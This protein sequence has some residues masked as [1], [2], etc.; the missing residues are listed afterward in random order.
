MS[1]KKYRLVV[2]FILFISLISIGVVLLSPDIYLVGDTE[3]TV[4]VNSEYKEKG[5]KATSFFKNVTNEVIIDDNVDTSKLGTYEITYILN[6]HGFKVKKKRIV[7]VVDKEAPIISLKGQTD[8]SVCP[9]QEYIEEGYEVL[10]NYDSNLQEKVNIEK[11]ENSV[12]YTVKDSSGNV[13]KVERKIKYQDIDKPIIT[14]NGSSEMSIYV[15][16]TY[17]EPGYSATDNCDGDISSKVVANGSVNSNVVGTYEIVY[18]VTDNSS[19]EVSVSRKVHVI[20][21]QNIVNG[22]GKKIFLT[23][24]D[25][26]SAT[27]T[28]S[29]LQIL[30]EE[31]V[32][33]TFFVINK[34]D[35]LNYLIKQAH[36]EGHTIALHSNTHNYA[37]IYSSVDNY[38]ADLNAISAKVESITGVK[39]KI[40]RFPGGGSNTVSRNY[41]VGIM[42]TLT[43][44]VV[45]QGYNYFDWN[46]AS[47]DAGGARTQY[48]VYNNVVNNLKYQNNIVLLHDFENNYKTLNA[49]RDIIRYGKSHGYTFEAITYNTPASRHRVNN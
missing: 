21:N 37:Y 17:S 7:I 44:M 6:I 16:T 14:L 48:D 18:T 13:G 22:V 38:F 24:D 39:S 33:A 43:N 5:Y 29:V 49:L 9:S 34:S 23:F 1:L 26:P 45:A 47:G 32:K 3:V 31:G 41:Q 40:I 4:D 10:D 19:N 15:G 35:S 28:P 11:K 46:V 42:T 36:D 20:Q 27:I 2:V 8:V 30:R 25:G 12:L